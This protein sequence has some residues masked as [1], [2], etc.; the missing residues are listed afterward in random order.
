MADPYRS[1]EPAPRPPKPYP[2]HGQT[3]A[4]PSG[5]AFTLVVYCW[6]NGWQGRFADAPGVGHREWVDLESCTY[7]PATQQGGTGDG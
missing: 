1:G 4:D 5:R 3:W 7:V 6:T 2:L